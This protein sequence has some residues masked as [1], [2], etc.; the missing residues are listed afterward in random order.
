MVGFMLSTFPAFKKDKRAQTIAK[1]FRVGG[2]ALGANLFTDKVMGEIL[3][4]LESILGN[5]PVSNALKKPQKLRVESIS[6]E[7]VYE[8]LEEEEQSKPAKHIFDVWH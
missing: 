1:E 3:P 5:L 7:P 2:M 4:R 8:Q 6:E